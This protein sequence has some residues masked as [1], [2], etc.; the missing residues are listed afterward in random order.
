[1]SL[2]RR[3]NSRNSRFPP[4]LESRLPEPDATDQRRIGQI[5]QE[6]RSAVDGIKQGKTRVRELIKRLTLEHTQAFRSHVRTL[7]SLVVQ[8]RE[9]VTEEQQRAREELDT[10]FAEMEK[11]FEA[12]TA[13][14]DTQ[15][16][17]SQDRVRALERRAEGFLEEFQ[18]EWKRFQGE[19]EIFRTAMREELNATRRDVD[20]CRSD[21]RELAETVCGVHDQQQTMDQQLAETRWQVNQME[22]GLGQVSRDTQERLR[23]Q[24]LWCLALTIGGAVLLLLV[25]LV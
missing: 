24:W 17:Q 4:R 19:N 3:R 9:C 1:M 15:I 5:T 7:Q 13:R 6:L 21:V 11:R 23:K 16:D 2:F 8:A 22:V 20:G 10:N 18:E 12:L 14:L 25:I